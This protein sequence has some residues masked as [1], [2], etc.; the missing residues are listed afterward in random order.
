MRFQEERIQSQQPD[1]LSL[2]VYLP[3][4]RDSMGRDQKREAISSMWPRLENNTCLMLSDLSL[5]CQHEF[6]KLNFKNHFIKNS[7]RSHSSKWG[8]Q[9]DT[10]ASPVH[11]NGPLYSQDSWSEGL[12]PHS[13]FHTFSVYYALMHWSSMKKKKNWQSWKKQSRSTINFLSSFMTCVSF[14][15][16]LI[17][18]P[19]DSTPCD[20]SSQH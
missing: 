4:S 8:T 20:L 18:W 2:A 16:H 11:P 19:P 6:L 12:E 7:Q 1:S 15:E 14:P 9:S 17:L 3:C 10:Y 13:E 5:G